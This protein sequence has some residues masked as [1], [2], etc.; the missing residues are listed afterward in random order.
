M[1]IKTHE[2]L[3]EL[4][5]YPRGRAKDK[6]L[7]SL[8]KHAVNFIE[9]SP[10]L[11]LSS[12]S[13]AGKM[14]VSPRGGVAGFVKVLD[15]V[16]IVI[17]DSKGNNRLDSFVNIVET[18]SIG[19]LF[20]IPGINETL[21]INGTAYISTDYEHLNLFNSENNP[22]KACIVI[23]IEEVFLHCA[24]ALMRS[25]LWLE[26]TKIERT[27]FPT[28]GEMLKDQLGGNGIIETQVEMEQRYQKDL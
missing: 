23:K 7:A 6:L 5:G 3:R 12:V 20:L 10:F 15:A 16:T 4:Y 1:K 25:K 28:M 17:P 9:N 21:R 14:D 18:E 11:T 27:D 13:K 8:D 26:D 24:K 19:T 22:P 2:Q